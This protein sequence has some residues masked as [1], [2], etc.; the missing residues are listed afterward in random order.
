MELLDT[1]GD[2]NKINQRIEF[3]NTLKELAKDAAWEI[4]REAS[5]LVNDE[6]FK[7]T[8][9]D[10]LDADR[11]FK[12]AVDN[13]VRHLANELHAIRLENNSQPYG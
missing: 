3:N 1:H 9:C 4:Y 2:M 5:E 7:M 12:T 8:D 10:S 6:W 11:A 13:F